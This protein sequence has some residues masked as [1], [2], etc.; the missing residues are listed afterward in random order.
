MIYYDPHIFRL[1]YQSKTWFGEWALSAEYQIWDGYKTPIVRIINNSGSIIKSDDFESVSVRNILVPKAGLKFD[2]TD[3][4]NFS[5]G[6]KY[7]PA[8]FDHSF[9][10]SGNSLDLGS[11]TV[12][13]GIGY[14]MNLFGTPI[15][16]GG[17]VQHHLLLEETI[18]K[19]NLLEN[20]A[21]GSKI[22][23]P[24]FTAG[25]SITVFSLGVNV[26]L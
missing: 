13:G 18:V 5:L 2:L 8:I 9:N 6:A 17:A 26:K 19:T 16:L 25:G 20:G 3:D 22:G 15:E 4:M 10:G 23:A 21:A 7:K 1:G 24:G 14:N 12:S 11:M